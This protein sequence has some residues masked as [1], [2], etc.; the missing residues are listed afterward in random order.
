MLSAIYFSPSSPHCTL[1]SPLPSDLSPD[2]LDNGAFNVAIQDGVHAGQT[3]PHVHVHVIPR[4]RGNE[5]GDKIYGML[6]GEEG[7][8]GGVLWDVL[9]RPGVG[10][11][12]ETVDDESRK[13]R[14]DEVMNV[15]ARMFERG[16]RE[17]D[18]EESDRKGKG[19]MV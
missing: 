7:N 17:L 9:K 1:P 18:E 8:V 16:M 5:L 14:D 3:V 19:S 15:E 12:M 2:P 4:A 13:V 10:K 6:Q 11:P